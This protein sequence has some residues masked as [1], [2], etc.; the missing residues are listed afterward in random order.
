M[1]LPFRVPVPACIHPETYK[2]FL[3]PD[4]VEAAWAGLAARFGQA[5]RIA[6]VGLRQI[7]GERLIIRSVPAGNPITVIRTSRCRVTDID[8]LHAIVGFEACSP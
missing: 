2:Y 5:R 8:E 4:A 3:E 7:D 1:N 6:G